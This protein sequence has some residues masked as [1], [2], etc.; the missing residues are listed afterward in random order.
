[1]DIPVLKEKILENDY[2]P[3]ILEELGCHHISKKQN[4]IN[5]QILMEIIILQ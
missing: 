3:I 4:G 5:V 2:V 1:M